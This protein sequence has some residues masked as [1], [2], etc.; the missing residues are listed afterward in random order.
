MQFPKQAFSVGQQGVFNFQ[1]KKLLQ[2]V[3]KVGHLGI[4]P[5]LSLE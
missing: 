5:W 2:V 1:D 3:I 4:E